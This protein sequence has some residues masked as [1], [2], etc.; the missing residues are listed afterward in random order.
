MLIL[1][2]AGG[3][4]RR[5]SGT[6]AL[7]PWT[8]PLKPN[9]KRWNFVWRLSAQFQRRGVSA[10]GRFEDGDLMRTVEHPARLPQPHPLC[11]HR[12]SCISALRRWEREAHMDIPVFLQYSVPH[13]PRS[14]AKF[15][16]VWLKIAFSVLYGIELGILEGAQCIIPWGL[17]SMRNLEMNLCFYVSATFQRLLPMK[18]YNLCLRM[19]SVTLTVVYLF[20][21]K[22]VFLLYKTNGK[23]SILFSKLVQITWHYNML[24]SLKI[25]KN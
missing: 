25:W 21:D 23:A 3:S 1:W 2:V 7:T 13:P 19:T 5:Q 12:R 10:H 22:S 15:C 6:H 14:W 18:A 24:F 11:P 20:K 17:C 8:S 9:S 16:T 4:G